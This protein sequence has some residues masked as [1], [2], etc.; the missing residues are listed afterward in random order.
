MHEIQISRD[1]SDDQRQSMLSWLRA[2]NES[3]NGDFMRSLSAGAEQPIFLAAELDDR[4]V[5]GLDGVTI[6][7]WLKIDLMAVAPEFRRQGI[8]RRLVDE[9]IR[10][11]RERDCRFAYVDT[12]SYQ[13]PEFYLAQG[14]VEAGRLVNWDSHG[15]DKLF[16]SMELSAW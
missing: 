4:I 13:A 2:F 5:G 16:L 14:F 3:E 11:A 1:G 9:S 10:I 12:M 7:Q 15:H 6:H 8:G